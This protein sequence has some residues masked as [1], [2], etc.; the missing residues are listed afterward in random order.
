[1]F[2]S[3]EYIC[4]Y[5]NILEPLELYLTSV[6]LKL[7]LDMYDIY[8]IE[9]VDGYMFEG[10]YGMFNDYIDYWNNQKIEAGKEKNA[11]KRTIAKLMLNSCYGKFASAVKSTSKV[12]YLKD[13]WSV[14]YER[15]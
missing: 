12:P 6:D 11:S 1:M 4:E 13:D 9:Y 2:A 10:A 8:Y 14:G 15:I 3:T 5:D 7:F